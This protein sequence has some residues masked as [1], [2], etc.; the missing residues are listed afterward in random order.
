MT[1]KYLWNN[2]LSLCEWESHQ[3]K[4]ESISKHQHRNFVFSRLL[5]DSKLVAFSVFV[6]QFG[7]IRYPLPPHLRELRTKDDVGEVVRR[8]MKNIVVVKGPNNAVIIKDL[9]G[10]FCFNTSLSELNEARAMP[11]TKQVN[12]LI[13]QFLS[14]FG[15]FPQKLSDPH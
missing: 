6:V 7:M 14:L 5:F 3:V 12:N 11:R 9:Q 1:D 15:R 4:N 8:C 10:R 13:S 2:L